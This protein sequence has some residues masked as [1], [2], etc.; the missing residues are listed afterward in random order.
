MKNNKFDQPPQG[1][2]PLAEIPQAITERLSEE[3]KKLRGILSRLLDN[4]QYMIPG[5]RRENG[6]SNWPPQRTDRGMV[7]MLVGD[8]WDARRIL[9]GNED[10]APFQNEKHVFEWD[11]EGEPRSILTA[12]GVTL[13]HFDVYN[14]DQAIDITLHKQGGFPVINGTRVPISLML[15]D[16]AEGGLTLSEFADI[17]GLY[18]ADCELALKSLAN[19]FNQRFCPKLTD[20]QKSTGE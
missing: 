5:I 2:A 10:E 19:F 9:S 18:D 13:R 16:L 8:Y 3:N 1:D 4:G 20:E 14:G 12:G 17:Y 7:Y 6:D 11:A 15:A